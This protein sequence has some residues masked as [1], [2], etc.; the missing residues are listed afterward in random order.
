MSVFINWPTC[1]GIRAMTKD[2]QHIGGRYVELFRVNRAAMIQ[3]TS[4][5]STWDALEQF[6]GGYMNNMQMQQ[7]AF[8]MYGQPQPYAGP[9][10]GGP[11]YPNMQVPPGPAMPGPASSKPSTLR[12]R[13]L[14]FRATVEE[15]SRLWW[16]VQV[17][18]FF[19]GFQLMPGGVVLG[20]RDGR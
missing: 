18:E 8:G 15:F 19:T 20:Q 1:R 6:V 2:R 11:A 10:V 12:M 13:G 16:S 9:F 5:A 17:C 4:L 7:P 3:A 14:P